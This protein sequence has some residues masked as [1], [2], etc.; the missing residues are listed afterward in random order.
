LVRIPGSLNSK[1]I[2]KEHDAEVK[3]IQKWDGTRS[4]IQSLLRDFRMWLAQKRIDDV[5]ELKRQEKFQ[6]TVSKNQE[7]TNSIKW[8]EKGVLEHLNTLAI[9]D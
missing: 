9:S 5:E 8:I 3:I 6:M 4:L 7:R 1:W 2:I